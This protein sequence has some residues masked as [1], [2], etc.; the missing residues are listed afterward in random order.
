MSSAGDFTQDWLV[1]PIFGIF[2][3]RDHALRVPAGKQRHDFGF[4]II[5]IGTAEIAQRDL[6]VVHLDVLLIHRQR[7]RFHILLQ[8]SQ[9]EMPSFH[10]SYFV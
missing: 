9:A 3:R 2:L 8:R 5:D 10:V 1:P 4:D 6:N 7:L